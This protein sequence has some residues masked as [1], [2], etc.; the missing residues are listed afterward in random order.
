MSVD[1]ESSDEDS[2]GSFTEE[3]ESLY[4]FMTI[5]DV[6]HAGDNFVDKAA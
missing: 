6:M 3:I 2:D 1:E 5:H 4:R